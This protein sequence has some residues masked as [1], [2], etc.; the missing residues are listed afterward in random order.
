[1]NVIPLHRVPADIQSAWDVY[2]VAL[3]KHRRE[4]ALKRLR[5]MGVLA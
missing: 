1:M 3:Q 4:T 2:Q 5:E